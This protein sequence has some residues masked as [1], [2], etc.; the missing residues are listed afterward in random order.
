MEQTLQDKFKKDLFEKYSGLAFEALGLYNFYGQQYK[1]IEDQIKHAEDMA[2]KVQ[3]QIDDLK[4][5]PQA[6]TFENRKK[7][8]A[9]ITDVNSYT[10][11]AKSGHGA[12]EKFFKEATNFQERGTKYLD[13]AENFKS[14]KLKTPEEIEADK[15]AKAE[16]PVK[17]E[18]KPTE[19][20]H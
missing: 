20:N 10:K 11:R 15:K 13:Q 2:A 16:E 17:V 1:E 14:F 5:S 18:D 8:K 6:H 12:R 7:I 4:N 19:E 9:L 3:K